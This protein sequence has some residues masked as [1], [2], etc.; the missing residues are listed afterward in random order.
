[1]KANILVQT[2][3]LSYEE[4]LQYRRC[5]IGG[6]DVAAILGISKWKSAIDIWLDKTGQA[7]VSIETNE[8]MQWGTLLE[9]VIRNHFAS[10]TN[11]KTVMEV[12][13]ILQHP[14]YPY[15]IADVDG[16]TTDNDGNPAI[17]EIKCASEFLRDEWSSGI[18]NYYRT[19]IQHY[20]C[21]AGVSKAYVAVLIGGNT[22]YVYED[23]ADLEIQHMLIA[24]EQDFWNKVVMNI[25]PEVDGS[26]AAKDLLDRIYVGGNEEEIT[27][28][29][30]TG[31][32]LEKYIEASVNEDNAKALKQEASNH[33]KELMGDHERARYMDHSISWKPVTSERFDAKL[34]KEQEP[35]IYAKYVKNST[36]RRF[37]I[38]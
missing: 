8:A 34:L 33:I 10:V 25:R 5:G 12:K 1:M 6:S 16:I 31:I 15:M 21:V 13:A 23:D 2:E 19:Q 22:F 3:G 4:W 11:N 24:V 38:K 7:G 30:D 29:E 37:L 32:W 17:L 14:E 28:P 26:N 27:L 9:P 20:M 36:C 18:P 35:A